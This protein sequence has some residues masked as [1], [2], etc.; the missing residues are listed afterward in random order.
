MVYLSPGSALNAIRLKDQALLATVRS[1]KSTNDLSDYRLCHCN[2]T[3]PPPK[4]GRTHTQGVRSLL[5]LP[6][7]HRAWHGQRSRHCPRSWAATG[8]S[9]FAEWGLGEERA[10]RTRYPGLPSSTGLQFFVGLTTPYISANKKPFRYARE[11]A[12]GSRHASI[13]PVRKHSYVLFVTV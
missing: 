9:L 4:R 5:S 11:E 10:P 2:C 1:I 6:A 12:T 8:R 3:L 7:C 13:F